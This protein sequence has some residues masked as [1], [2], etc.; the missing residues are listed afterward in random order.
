MFNI[1]LKFKHILTQLRVF[2]GH[3]EPIQCLK[4]S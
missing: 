2:L 3:I 4:V 1:C